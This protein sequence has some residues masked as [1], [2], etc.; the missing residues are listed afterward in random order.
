MLRMVHYKR[1][2]WKKCE[3]NENCE[4]VSL[5]WLGDEFNDAHL[6]TETT[7]TAYDS[8]IY[9]Y[10]VCNNWGVEWYSFEVENLE[11]RIR[12]VALIES[13]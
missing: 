2:T 5:K 9:L 6:S 3:E 8:R 13:M 10:E 11:V 12:S 1:V 7:T 4:H